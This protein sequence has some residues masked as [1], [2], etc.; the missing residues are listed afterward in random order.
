MEIVFKNQELEGIFRTGKETGKPRYGNVIVKAFVKTVIIL[1]RAPN[2]MLL[3]K[4]RS[5]HF[6]A[7]KHDL[8][9][10]HSVRVNDQYRLVFKVVKKG[11]KVRIIVETIEI[12][13]LED[14][15]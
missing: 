9:G 11:L 6:E 2:T 10:Y 5:L 3:T 12:H 7:L 8:K 13:S 15:H 14:Y 4:F 1:K